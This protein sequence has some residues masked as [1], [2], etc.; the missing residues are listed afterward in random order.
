MI[1]GRWR[2]PAARHRRR[3]RRYRGRL[4]HMGVDVRVP[5]A[6][7]T[8]PTQGR[9][10]RRARA[11][12]R[13][14]RLD[15]GRA[16]RRAVDDLP[17]ERVARRPDSRPAYAPDDHARQY[18]RDFVTRPSGTG[19]RHA[20]GRRR[21]RCSRAITL[22]DIVRLQAGLPLLPLLPGQGYHGDGGLQRSRHPYRR[23][24]LTPASLPGRFGW[25]RTSSS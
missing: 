22:R 21:L 3:R 6:P 12:P 5:T 1:R 2:R 24:S 4:A 18:L 19:R 10:R 7:C 11:S 8:H 25:R 15:S 23:P 9:G 17:I 13:Q 14:R 20:A 16:R